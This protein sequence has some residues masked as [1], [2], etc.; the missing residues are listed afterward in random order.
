MYITGNVLGNFIENIAVELT[1]E[2]DSLKYKEHRTL[3]II[4]HASKIL[5]YEIKKLMNF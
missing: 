4:T 2:S 3:N 1:N 5:T